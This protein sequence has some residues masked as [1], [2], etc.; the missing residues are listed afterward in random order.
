MVNILII[1][2]EAKE[3]YALF[4]SAGFTPDTQESRNR[5]A[6]SAADEA[7]PEKYDIAFLDLDSDG[8]RQRLLEIRHRMPVVTFSHPELKR[9]VEAMKLGACD[10][11]E[12]PLTGDV[13]LEVIEKYKKHIL[14]AK[15]GFDEIIGTSGPMQGVFG[16]IKKAAAS[17]SNVFI[18]GESGTGKE[19]IAR[20]EP[21]ERKIVHDHQ[22]Q[23]NSRHA[24]RVGAFW[25]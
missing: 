17:E 11:L 22:L 24:S 21:A 6:I 1:S 15:Y 16:L 3:I 9:A 20:A 12:K 23:C 10:F 19:L 13:L 2:D 14:N 8:W 25:F 5:P 4:K 7:E 18:T